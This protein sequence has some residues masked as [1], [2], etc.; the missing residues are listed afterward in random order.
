MREV[1]EGEDMISCQCGA[2]KMSGIVKAKRKAIKRGQ[3]KIN[4]F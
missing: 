1:V 3:L 4:F 2:M